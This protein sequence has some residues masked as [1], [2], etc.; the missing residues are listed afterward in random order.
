MS[1]QFLIVGA[2]SGIGAALARVLA[3]RGCGLI[4]AGRNPAELARSA[5]DLKIRYGVETSVETCDAMDFDGQP[6]FVTRCVERAG[7]R[8]DGAV[9]CVG[10]LGDQRES[11]QEPTFARH[12]IDVNFTATASLL[13]ELANVLER[14]GSGLL[15]AVSSVAGDRGRQSNYTYGAAKAG[16]SVFL[17]GL[18][19]RLRRHGVHVLTIKPGFVDTRMTVGVVNPRSPILASPERV[20]RDIDRAIRRKVDVLYT[21]WFWRGIMSVICAIPERVFK[22]LSL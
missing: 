16:L 11:E 12:V 15:A 10:Q 14:Q 22:R 13:G 6:Q 1:E 5:A 21:P 4:L 8:I 7:G 18:R 3:E 17:Q 9:L 20:A 19:N 2:S